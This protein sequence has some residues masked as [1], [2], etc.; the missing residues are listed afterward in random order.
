MQGSPTFA[1]S[2]QGKESLEVNVKGVLGTIPNQLHGQDTCQ[3][4][5]T[6]F[7]QVP[8]REKKSKTI[9]NLERRKK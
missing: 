3:V 8:V 9:V 2:H 1:A 4:C 7:N 5:T 6:K